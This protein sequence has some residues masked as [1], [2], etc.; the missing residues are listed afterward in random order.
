MVASLRV[1]PD[2][3]R[4]ASVMAHEAGAA[5][6]L[7]FEF[8]VHGLPDPL[9]PVIDGVGL[10]PVPS[11]GLRAC[12]SDD[13]VEQVLS[14]LPDAE[15]DVAPGAGA[16][17][18][19]EAL[20]EAVSATG[21]LDI[22]ER[23]IGMVHFEPDPYGRKGGLTGP[24]LL[25][26]LDTLDRRGAMFGERAAFA[27]GV[28]NW[29]RRSVAAALCAPGSGV[30]FC[31]EADE[32]IAAARRE[33]G[34]V[35]A[36]AGQAT[37][38]H[39]ASAQRAG[40]EFWR[41]EDGFLRSVG[42]GAGL[43]GGASYAVDPLGIYFDATRASRFEELV[44]GRDLSPA[45]RRRARSLRSRLCDSGLTKY[46]LAA[47]EQVAIPEGSGELILVPGQVS[48]D[49]GVRRTISDVIDCT[50]EENV[51]LALLRNVRAR[52]PSARILY[53]P[54]PDVEAGLR[55]G[56]IPD[57]EMAGLV[58]GIVRGAGIL[59]TLH[60]VDRVETFSSLAGFEALLRDVPVTVHGMP[61]YA[62]WGVSEDLTLSPARRSG[63]AD[64]DTLVHA[65]YVDYPFCI[66]PLTL[67]P[68]PPEILLSRLSELRGSRGHR[69]AM[70]VRQRLSWLGR[71]IGI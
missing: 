23:L 64:L 24:E 54:H 42:L 38:G 4:A 56:A 21:G 19:V 34:R 30:T 14:A 46:N 57:A 52:N 15:L 66:D 9:M 69:V 59:E 45:E 11:A 6:L 36:W 70:G 37:L 65:A 12:A 27:Y 71:R 7:A 40:V 1:K 53:K 31:R 68:C 58:D 22:F 51:N 20:G 8:Q 49:A 55:K 61:F 29:N 60:A 25:A 13:P 26:V 32:A 2:V 50:G 17:P 16:L 28:R 3:L 48:D 5:L 43:V 41:I 33:N 18:L 35:L 10:L 44:R 47:G 62:G 67:R 63:G 39:E